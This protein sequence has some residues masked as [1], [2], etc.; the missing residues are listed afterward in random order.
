[1]TEMQNPALATTK[2]PGSAHTTRYIPSTT[3][4]ECYEHIQESCQVADNQAVASQIAGRS[5]PPARFSLLTE[6]DIARLPPLRWRVR[7]VL[8]D[9]GLAAI[10]GASGSGKSFLAIDLAL[11]LAEGTKWFGH[12]VKSC[13]VVY[14]ALEGEA[15]IV[16][17]VI[18]HR[19]KRGNT[20]ENLRFVAQ[21]FKLLEPD[22]VD[23]LAREISLAFGACGVFIL[24]TLNR[25][26]PG[27]D[28]NDSKDMGRVIEATKLLQTRLGCLVILIHHSGKDASRGLRGHSSLHAA[29]DSA[30]EVGRDNDRHV[31]K[32][33][34]SKDGKDSIS[35]TFLLDVVVIGQDEDG[36]PITSCVIKPL[37]SGEQSVRRALSPKSGNQ[38]IIWNA[39]GEMMRNATTFGQNGA[40]EGKPCVQVED[41]IEATRGRLPCDPKRQTERTRAAVTGLVAKGLCE[42]RNGWLWLT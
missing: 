17:R 28:E 41:V 15:G 1:M 14:C 10:F 6:A 25:A 11:S 21:P 4:P 33:H 39:L 3:S 23:E 22:D 2:K 27:I 9:S 5:A 7:D 35:H 16:G 38:K 26:A 20:S 37:E 19:T 31:W 13:Y 12:R 8:P 30:I 34:K 32:L 40:P 36:E 24:D 29:L 42:I 18:A